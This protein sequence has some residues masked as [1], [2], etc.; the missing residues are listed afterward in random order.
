MNQPTAPQSPPV[1]PTPEE[2]ERFDAALFPYFVKQR[3]RMRASGTP[4]VHYTS[5]DGAEGILKGRSVWLRSTTCMNDYSEARHGYDCLHRA[6]HG[7][8]GRALRDALDRCH[9]GIAGDTAQEFDK[10]TAVILNGSFV[11]CL[12]EH[13]PKEDQHGRLSMWRAYC[14]PTGLALVLNSAPFFSKSDAL[15]AYSSPVAYLSDVEFSEM[16][17]KIAANVDSER[18]ALSSMDRAVMLHGLLNMLKSAILCTKHPAFAE[19]REWRVVYTPGLFSS[20]HLKRNVR[21]IRGVTQTVYDLPLKDIPAE[22]LVGIE[23]PQLLRKIIIGPTQYSSATH[24]ALWHLLVEAGVTDPS[25]RIHVSGVP[26][27]T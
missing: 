27:R 20:E 8:S 24:T 6:W 11:A 16:I 19:E 2:W 25:G 10:R 22:G 5:G 23:I 18:D 12:S 13:D 7:E 1:W 3:D 26:L 15:K 9:Q 14:N 21:T 17:H 4:F